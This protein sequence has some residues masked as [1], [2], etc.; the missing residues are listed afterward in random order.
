MSY[1]AERMMQQRPGEAEQDRQTDW[2]SEEPSRD[3]V[4]LC[5]ASEGAQPKHCR[6]KAEIERRAGH[7]M[8]DR[9]HHGQGRPIGLQI[10]REWSFA[11]PCIGLLHLSPH[12]C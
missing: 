12:H 5:A 6:D 7:P 3:S 8:Y 2:R 1:S 4:S 11:T 9:H 10:G